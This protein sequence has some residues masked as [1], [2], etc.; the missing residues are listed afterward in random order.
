MAQSRFARR[1]APPSSARTRTSSEFKSCNWS[2]AALSKPAS[3]ELAQVTQAMITSVSGQ[4]E[5]VGV[6]KP[7]DQAKLSRLIEWNPRVHQAT[8]GW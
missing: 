5:P 3:D 1:P 4:A 8:A 7:R 6:L 2:P